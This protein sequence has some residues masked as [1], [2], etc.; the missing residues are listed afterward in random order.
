MIA[1]FLLYLKSNCELAG[2][3]LCGSVVVHVDV[4][5]ITVSQKWGRIILSNVMQ[6]SFVNDNEEARRNKVST[7]MLERLKIEPNFLLRS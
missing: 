5:F 6:S 3:N 2:M 7:E 1:I 4:Y